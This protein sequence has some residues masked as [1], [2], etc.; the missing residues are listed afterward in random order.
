LSSASKSLQEIAMSILQGARNADRGMI[1]NKLEAARY[2]TDQMRAPAVGS[3]YS[4]QPDTFLARNWLRAVDDQAPSLLNAKTGFATLAG[5]MAL[6]GQPQALSGFV[7]TPSPSAQA[8]AA[9]CFGVPDGYVPVASANVT[10]V[11]VLGTSG[12]VATTDDCGFFVT[13]L[14]AG[15]PSLRIGASGYRTFVSTAQ[16]FQDSDGNGLPDHATLIPTTSSYQLTGVIVDGKTVQF[17]LIDSATGKAITGLSSANVPIVS[18]GVPLAAGNTVYAAAMEFKNAIIGLVLDASGSMGDAGSV[19]TTQKKIELAGAATQLFITRKA[20]VDLMSLTI[21]DHR[22][23]FLDSAGYQQMITGLGACPGTPFAF[24]TQAGTA[25]G[26]A[27][28]VNGHTNDAQFLE[29][30]VKFYNWE[31]PSWKGN[32]PFFNVY[33]PGYTATTPFHGSTA[34]YKATR[35]AVDAIGPLVPRRRVAIVMTEGLD[36]SSGAETA[37]TVAAAAKQYGVTVHTI[38]VG[39]YA[40]SSGLTTMAN[41][42]GG[43]FRQVTDLGQVDALAG[44]FDAVRTSIAYQ[45]ATQLS[46][47]PAY[48]PLQVIVNVGGT[49]IVACG[50]GPYGC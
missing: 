27:V 39:S 9:T 3:A 26:S 8:P 5:R 23:A 32:D 10:Q 21:F 44:A 6:A 14:D 50:T 29:Q 30:M 46:A 19:S 15:T 35:P 4:T 36:S 31:S 45:Y 25:V 1:A 2:F 17:T 43:M 12:R 37:A 41:Q 22:V 20:R 38:A 11:N 49:A 7:I 16:A 48:G 24:R 28:P 33:R 40:D 47:V 18:N 13:T 42:T 34:M